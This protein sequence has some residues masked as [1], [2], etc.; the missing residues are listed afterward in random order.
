MIERLFRL[1]KP[2]RFYRSDLR[3][4]VRAYVDDVH[5]DVLFLV[6]H[7]HIDRPSVRERYNIIFYM[8]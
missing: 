2:N 1:V 4:E 8:L 7:V 5:D 3:D 6:D